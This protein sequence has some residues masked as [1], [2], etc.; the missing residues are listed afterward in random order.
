MKNK[1]Y[2]TD[3]KVRQNITKK[4]PNQTKII[5]SSRIASIMNANKILV[6]DNGEL[7]AFDNHHNLIKNCPIYKEMVLSQLGNEGDKN[8]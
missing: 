6:L 1:D 2:K 3:L 4:Y 5:I 8:E 7:I